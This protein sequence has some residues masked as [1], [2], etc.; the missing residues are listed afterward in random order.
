MKFYTVPIFVPELACPNRC[1]FCNQHSISGC[2]AQPQPD[3]VYKIIDERLNTIPSSNTHIDIGFFGGNF[4]GISENLQKEYLSIASEYLEKKWV[5]GIRLSTRPDYITRESLE[6]L[7]E[8]KV[9]TIELG[10]Q[11]LDE[12]VL[13][14]AGRGHSVADVEKASALILKNGFMLG[15]QMMTGLPGDTPEKAIKTAQRIISLGAH[16]TRIY[17]TIVIRG[18]ELEKLW[19]NGTYKPQSMEEAIDLSATLISVFR[20]SGV[21]IL[22]VGLHPSEDLIN[23]SEI[24]AGPFHVSFRQLAE[25]EIWRRKIVNI[26][27]NEKRISLDNSESREIV[28]NVPS[29]ELNEAIGYGASNRQMLLKHFSRVKFIEESTT[30]K[31]LP[32]IIADRRIPLPAKNAL[33]QAGDL[34]L[35]DGSLSTYKS[36]S[37]H[38]DIFMCAGD[39]KVVVS[40]DM[41]HTITEKIRSYGYSVIM[42]KK[43]PSNKYPGSAIYNA[44]I[45]NNFLIHNLK[46]TDENLLKAFHNKQ[47]IQV[48]QGYTRCN[49]LS[50]G[51]NAFITSDKGID[52][53]LTLKGFE[54]LYVD[55]SPVILKGHKYGFFPGCCGVNGHTVF[56]NGSLKYHYM[57]DDIE[58]FISRHGFEVRELFDGKLTDIGG[59]IFLN[60]IKFEL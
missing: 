29:G 36:I 3:E 43:V 45:T 22:R 30:D 2:Q 15:L 26:L 38:P 27:E 8:Y 58:D 11:S 31:N 19:H 28:I 59:I 34:V 42:G 50:I 13:K 5:H 10:A 24:V 51:D 6:L 54:V 25:T 47:Y 16:S 41:D 23:G 53:V 14:L 48:F 55:P 9:T 12:E 17:P 49:L 18:T 7:R 57:K 44:V 39:D 32:L 4:T 20:E 56:I 1:V 40:P 37:G 21:K 33:R 46:I 52:K 35:L 60:S